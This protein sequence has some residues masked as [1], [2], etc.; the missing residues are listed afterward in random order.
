MLNLLIAIRLIRLINENNTH[1]AKMVEIDAEVQLVMK[2]D[3]LIATN[4]N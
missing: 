4:G 1:L 3:I 2:K